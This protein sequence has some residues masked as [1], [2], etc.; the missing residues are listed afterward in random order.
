MKVLFTRLWREGTNRLVEIIEKL[1]IWMKYKR[2]TLP[3]NPQRIPLPKDNEKSLFIKDGVLNI[4]DGV[5]GNYEVGVSAK[6]V[7]GDGIDPTGATPSSDGLNAFFTANKRGDFYIPAG[8]YLLDKAVKLYESATYTGAGSTPYQ[9]TGHVPGVTNPSGTVFFAKEDYTF[10]TDDTVIIEDKTITSITFD[11]DLN[12]MTS[13]AMLMSDSGSKYLFA[14]SSGSSSTAISSGF[15]DS[16]YTVDGVAFDGTRGELYTLLAVSG[17]HEVAITVPSIEVDLYFGGGS[18]PIIGQIMT[19]ISIN[20]SPI[21]HLFELDAQ[22]D[23]T[24]F[25]SETWTKTNMSWMHNFGFKSFGVDGDKVADYGMK[26][27]QMGEVGHITD[28]FFQSFRKAGVFATGAHAPFTMRNCSVGGAGADEAEV[29]P[30]TTPKTYVHTHPYTGLH[31]GKHPDVGGTGNLGGSSGEVRLIGLSGDHN[32]GGIIRVSGG[33]TVTVFGAKFENNGFKT[34]LFDAQGLGGNY[35]KGGGAASITFIGG[36]SQDSSSQ[37]KFSEELIRIEEGVTPVVTMQGFT[38]TKGS[39]T[40]DKYDGTGNFYTPALIR[41]DVAVVN[42]TQTA[43]TGTV[44]SIPFSL[45]SANDLTL[46]VDGTLSTDDVTVTGAGTGTVTVT[47]DEEYT[48]GAILTFK[49]EDV[50]PN[51]NDLSSVKTSMLTYGP[52]ISQLHSNIQLGIGTKVYGTLSNGTMGT[53]LELNTDQLTALRS[54]NSVGAGMKDAT[55]AL[56]FKINNTG[57]GFNAEGPIAM[58]T[59]TGSRASVDVMV[60]LLTALHNYGLIDNQTD[61]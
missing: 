25:V 52:G 15:G 33:Q 9:P 13:E 59:I 39:T 1:K 56:K 54:V 26:I 37:Y 16:T 27:Y 36:N 32:N 6:I 38:Y 7:R 14:Y 23:K 34:I 50:I 53:M 51:L 40:T 43:P 11:I 55:G 44:Y 12:S 19:K 61:V 31:F 57:V 45:D 41:S 30:N 5:V 4:D 2:I 35:G 29:V 58:P 21:W 17:V 20:G 49:R 3:E 22:G 47:T 60:N 46:Y 8:F 42:Y 18:L 10:T 28:C 24:M 48:V